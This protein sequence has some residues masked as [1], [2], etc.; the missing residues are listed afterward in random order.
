[1]K[2]KNHP[3][4]T[5]IFHNLLKLHFFT[6]QER[7]LDVGQAHSDDGGRIKQNS[8][9][10]WQDEMELGD[11]DWFL[12]TVDPVISL[13]KLW[14]TC[15]FLSNILFPSS[16]NL[17]IFIWKLWISTDQMTNFAKHPLRQMRPL[18]T[19]PHENL[20]FQLSFEL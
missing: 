16:S 3:K 7:W 13:E 1:M 8:M 12:A 5:N 15:L 17:I 19:I 14:P 9:K 2:L 4:C 18:L 11:L 6:L 10:W 20:G